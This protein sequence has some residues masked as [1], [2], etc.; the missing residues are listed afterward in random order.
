MSGVDN[1]EKQATI[2][3]SH[4]VTDALSRKSTDDAEYAVSSLIKSH[5][6]AAESQEM[7]VRLKAGRPL[8]VGMEEQ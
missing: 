8:T 5:P 4:M 6:E 1:R 2:K 7:R 3:G